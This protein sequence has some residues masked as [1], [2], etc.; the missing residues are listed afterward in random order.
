MAIYSSDIADRKQS[1]EALKKRAE[2]LLALHEISIEITKPHVVSELLQKIVKRATHLLNGT[3]GGM[4]LCDPEKKEVRCIV[5]YKTPRDFTGTVLKYGEGTA[6]TVAQTGEP[7][8]IADYNAWINRAEVFEKYQPFRSVMSAPLTWQ[9]ETIGVIHVLDNERA[10]RFTEDDLNL[11]TLFANQAVAEFLSMRISDVAVPEQHPSIPKILEQLFSTG[12]AM[13]ETEELAK[14]GRRIPVEVSTRLFEL[15]DI[16]TV[17]ATVRDI[18]ERKRAEEAL[19]AGERK[20]RTL[21]QNIPGMVYKGYPDWSGEIISGSVEVC[22][23]TCEEIN[24][25]DWLSIVHPDDKDRIF[26]EGSEL[27]KKQQHWIQI[28]RIKDKKDRTRWVEDHK[29]SLFSESGEFLGVDG[30]V[31]DVTEPKL[32]KEERE[33]LI[34]RLQKALA[35]VKTLKG[36]LPICASCKKIRDDRGYWKQVESYIRDHSEAEFSHGICPECMKKLYSDFI[37]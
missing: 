19:Q 6:G 22:G 28:Y 29:A 27:S 2:Q 5:S 25:K 4:Y 21:I 33:E 17:L 3:G 18:T 1:E 35:E 7:L 8:I 15:Q 30:V 26:T 37:D 10:G 9:N 13:F 31:F 36:I 12:H 14:G 34:L 23:F 24:S 11:L 20:Y 32:A 16:P